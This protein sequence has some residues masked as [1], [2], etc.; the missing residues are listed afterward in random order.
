VTDPALELDRARE[1]AAAALRRLGHAVVGHEADAA[2]LLRIAELADSTAAGV[3][4]RTARSRPVE[5]MKR[6]LWE[7][8]PAD[9]APMSHFPECVV[10]GQANPMG[11][12]IHVRRD[13]EAAVAAFNLGP[14]FE[15]APGRAHGGVVA[16]VFD[17]V[18]GYVLVVHR[19]PAF[20]GRL[21][22]NYRAP[23]PLGVD[24]SVRARLR[25]RSG[26]KLFMVAEMTHGDDVI[27]DAEGLFIAI[28]PERLG[29]PPDAAEVA[30]AGRP[31]SSSGA[32]PPTA[33]ER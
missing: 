16:A 13:G 28:P 11:V 8:P 12:G 32:L 10:S 30:G 27:C 21:T 4:T 17:D 5:V 2:L 31:N 9:G 26:R 19:V 22:V 15:G 18:M 7:Q 3:E 23:V 1:Q 6:R 33:H 14:A 29:L 24:L 25:N 20:T